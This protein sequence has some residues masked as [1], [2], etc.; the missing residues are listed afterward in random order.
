MN[1]DSHVLIGL[2]VAGSISFLIDGF[3]FGLSL[4][5]A[6]VG[7]IIG[8]LFPDILEPATHYTH[9]DFFHSVRLMKILGVILLISLPISFF[10]VEVRLIFY[11]IVGYEMHLLTDETTPMGLPE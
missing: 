4:G 5:Y 1:R 8:S 2:I 6:I 3:T 7:G 10:I 11:G 9:R